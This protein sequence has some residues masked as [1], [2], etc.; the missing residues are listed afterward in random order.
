SQL[1]NYRR[2]KSAEAQVE[3]LIR[4]FNTRKEIQRTRETEREVS[5]AMLSGEFG[6]LK[7]KLPYPVDGFR[8]VGGFGKAFDAKSGLYVFKKGIDLA[9]QFGENVKAISQGKVA[10][11]GE[12]PGYGQVVLLDHGDHFYS[13]YGHMGRVVKKNN[14]SVKR[15][16]TLGLTGDSTTP[17]YFEI[18]SRNVAVNPLQWLLN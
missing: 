17:L 7:G 1:E 14:D 12:L 10:F 3:G 6:K 11:A 18:R 2:L 5:K 8:L 16:E 15:G 4:H 13:L 9:T